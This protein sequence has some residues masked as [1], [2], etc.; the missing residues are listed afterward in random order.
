MRFQKTQL[1]F[2]V[3]IILFSCS[4]TGNKNV[5]GEAERTLETHYAEGFVINYFDDYKEILVKAPW[6]E[7]QM[8]ERYYLVM[9][10]KTTVPKDS[11]KIVV[12][13]KSLGVASCTS[14]EFLYMLNEAQSITGICSPELIYNADITNRY[15]KGGLA[16][17]GDA[18][19]L[20]FEQLLL[21]RPEAVMVS[22]FNQMNEQ[23]NR[24]IQA[25]IP[26]IYNNEWTEQSLLGRA[27]WIKFIA[28]FYDKEHEADSIFSIIESNYNT[29]K[30]MA[31]QVENKPTILSGSNFKG[32]W[33]MPGGKSYM[34]CLFSD[35]GSDY[36]YKNDTTTTSLPLSFEM[37]LKEFRD[38]DYW[39][40]SA[41]SMKELRNSDERYAL[42]K[43]VQTGKVYSSNNRTTPTGG[44]DF[45]ES[46]V[47]RPDLLLSD[48]I[49]VLHPELM[50]DYELVYVKKVE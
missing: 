44:N 49:K 27:E 35:A 10:E 39:I 48:L 50:L 25:G 23:D 34:G 40:C 43:A 7:N 1:L 8:L 31:Q 29:I 41:N 19:N 22:G 20:N 45:W 18:F 5:S 26:I 17:L 28:A 32:T 42:F 21:L 24:I 4:P 3:S 15:K 14:F 2:F 13:L 11:R 37:V 30:E 12:P 33:Y 6:A 9:D 47:A 16:N 36:F 46:A 38:A